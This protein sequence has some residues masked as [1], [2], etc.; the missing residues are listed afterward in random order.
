LFQLP[1]EVRFAAHSKRF[2]EE[3]LQVSAPVQLLVPV[4]LPDSAPEDFRP[5]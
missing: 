2:E 5:R 3:Q 4:A 1:P